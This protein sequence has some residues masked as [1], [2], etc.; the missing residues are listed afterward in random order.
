MADQV[1]SGL[2]DIGKIRAQIGMV[3]AVCVAL[4]LCT[5]GGMTIKSALGDK[6]TETTP[7]SLSQSTCMSNKCTSV[8]TYT[9]DGKQYT[10]DRYTTGS[11]VPQNNTVNYNPTNP[12]DAEQNKPPLGLGVGLIIG[13]ILVVLLGYLAYWLTTSFKPIAALEGADTVYNVGKFVL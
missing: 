12:E 2:A 9:V 4:S 8:A 10:F 5:C 1:Y 7:V 3:V 11:P 6:H 13:G